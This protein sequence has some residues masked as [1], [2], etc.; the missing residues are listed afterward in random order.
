VEVAWHGSW[1]IVGSWVLVW[2]GREYSYL[3]V[4]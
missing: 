3:H 1:L 4:V 2:Y